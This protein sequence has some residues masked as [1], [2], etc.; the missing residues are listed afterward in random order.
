M[1]CITANIGSKRGCLSATVSRVGNG[2]KANVG[3]VDDGL[4]AVIGRVGNGLKANIGIVCSVSTKI[5]VRFKEGKLTWNGVDNNK[6]V[7]K[8]NTIFASGDWSL[9][10]V[11]IEE[12][13]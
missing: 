13:L 1:G 11:Q 9:N 8:F 6:G 7:I 12:L 2:L 10:E 5:Y 3:I 4:I